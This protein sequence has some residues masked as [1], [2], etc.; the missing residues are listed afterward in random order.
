MAQVQLPIPLYDRNQGNITAAVANLRRAM[1]EADRVQLQLQQRLAEVWRRYESAQTQ[2]QIYR[3]QILPRARETLDL[4]TQ[5]YEGGQIDFLRVLT[6]RRTFFENQMKY[7]EALIELRQAE[8]ELQGFLL[9]G[10]LD[11]PAEGT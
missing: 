6:P 3:T 11:A 10:G 2:A 4:T 8:A 1:D 5:A 9:T 7:L